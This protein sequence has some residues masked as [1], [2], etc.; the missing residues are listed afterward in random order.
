MGAGGVHRG[1]AETVVLH[2]PSPAEFLALTRKSQLTPLTSRRTVNAVA[3]EIP[4][5]TV[6][7]EKLPPIFH[8]MT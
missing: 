5:S 3:V 4:S 8:S 6:V 1:M 2:S 7:H